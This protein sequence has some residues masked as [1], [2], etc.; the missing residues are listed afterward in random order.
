LAVD[1]APSA[2]PPSSS[3]SFAGSSTGASGASDFFAFTVLA[4]GLAV[5]LALALDLV[6]FGAA[7]AF[8]AVA[9]VS[10]GGLAFSALADRVVISFQSR[11]A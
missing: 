7:L 8:G 5:V 9:T 10:S 11:A 2:S 4:A 3:T 6:A 1:A